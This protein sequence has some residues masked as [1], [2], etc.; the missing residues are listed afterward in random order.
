MPLRFT[1]TD[2]TTNP[3]GDSTV[4][5]EPV[6]WDSTTLR[7]KRD[8]NWRGFFDFA[9]DSYNQMQWHGAAMAIL[10]DAYDTFGLDANCELKVE[11]ACS[12]TDSYTT[13]YLGKF[14]FAR[15]SYVCADYCYVECGVDNANCLMT[16]RNR[17]DQKVDLDS[18][19]PFDENSCGETFSLTNVY[20]VFTYTDTF[21]VYSNTIPNSHIGQW[22]TISNTTFN[23]RTVKITN[24]TYSGAN[25]LIT[26]DALMSLELGA[27][28]D[29]KSFCLGPY[30]ALGKEIV[31]PAKKLLRENKW[32]IANTVR[33]Y[34]DTV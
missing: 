3:A 11:Y 9:D 18:L 21:T 8:K 30:S 27:Y 12:E 14:A 28:G 7:L 23:N 13:V 34:T 16:F 6:G 25:T 2:Y 26:V 24:I 5:N 17:Y 31:L 10:K 32:E 33:N 4:V 15:Y 20:M 22:L 1:I 29:L 19:A